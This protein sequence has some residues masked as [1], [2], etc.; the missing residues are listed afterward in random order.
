MQTVRR[1]YLYAVAFISFQTCLWAA[2]GLALMVIDPPPPGS[3]LIMRLAGLLSA[4]IV[5]IPFYV[6]HWLIAQRQATESSDER[7]S[8]ARG[9]YHYGLM[10]AMA[11]PIIGSGIFV[12]NDLI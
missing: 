4:L 7:S 1:V 3:L 5:A 8:N 6:I 10:L 11:A 12:L 9:M 2:V